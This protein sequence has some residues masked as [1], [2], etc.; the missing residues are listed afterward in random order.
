MLIRNPPARFKSHHISVRALG[1]GCG[2]IFRNNVAAGESIKL[3]L[4][5]CI[6]DNLLLLV[7]RS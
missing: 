4:N 5:L 1:G 2:S 7:M 3:A 6:H